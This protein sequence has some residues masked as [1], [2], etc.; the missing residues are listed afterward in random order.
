[1]IG[2][3]VFRE[4][5]DNVWEPSSAA[6]RR[7][8]APMFPCRCLST[9]PV[10]FSHW[11][12]PADALRSFPAPER[13]HRR[14]RRAIIRQRFAGLATIPLQDPDLPRASSSDCVRDWVC[15][16]RRSAPTSTRTSTPAAIDTAESDN[17]VAPTASGAP[18]S[19][20]ERGD[21]RVHPWDMVGKERMPR[22]WLPWFVGMPAETS[23]AIC[24]MIFGGVFDCA[25]RNPRRL[26]PRRRRISFTIG[27]IEH[28]FHVRGRIWFRWRTNE[29]RNIP[30]WRWINRK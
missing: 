15:A 20:S 27:R 7:W 17:A 12:K 19:S 5:T 8:I 24:S 16:A 22:Y 25:F 1:M 13:S 30:A 3:R 9:V 26:R 23:L 21:L 18:R 29:L 11:A 14:S 10:M 4:I 2:D 28:G 6:S